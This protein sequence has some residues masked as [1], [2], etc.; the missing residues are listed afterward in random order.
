MC[1]IRTL[2]WELF[3]TTAQCFCKALNLKWPYRKWMTISPLMCSCPLC[4]STALPACVRA[5]RW[6]HS[7]SNRLHTPGLRM[8][9]NKLLLTPRFSAMGECWETHFTLLAG[10]NSS[11]S[12]SLQKVTLVSTLHDIN[13]TLHWVKQLCKPP[14][15]LS[16]VLEIHQMT[17]EIRQKFCISI[18]LVSVPQKA[19]G[20]TDGKKGSGDRLIGLS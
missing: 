10:T 14:S 7:R 17:E 15:C 16:K 8:L 19:L 2:K 18:D 9:A 12:V 1:W 5:Q 20:R 4:S 13:Y 11:R 3:S 6:G